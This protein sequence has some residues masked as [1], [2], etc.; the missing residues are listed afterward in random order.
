MNA[1]QTKPGPKPT[2]ELTD[3]QANLLKI[4]CQFKESHGISPT[5]Q[6]LAD[7]LGIRSPSVHNAIDVLIRKGH[8]RRIPHKARCL[9]VIN[10]IAILSTELISLPILGSIAAGVSMFAAENICGEVLV[11]PSIIK[12]TCF[13]LKVQGDSMIDANIA[14]G[15]LIIIRKQALAESGDIVA[16]RING[17]VTVKRLKIQDTFIELRPDN[18][19]H[20]SIVVGADDDL[21]IIGKVVAVRKINEAQ[22]KRDQYEPADNHR[23]GGVPHLYRV[24]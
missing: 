12:G 18:P 16:A 22:G 11:E 20:A 17:E 24:C 23:T 15:N 13:A 1:L 6:E 7:I 21:V 9:E 4:I 10:H 8:I 19:H 5:L 14:D 2:T 3:T